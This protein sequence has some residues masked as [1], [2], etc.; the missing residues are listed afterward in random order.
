MLAVRAFAIAGLCMLI[1]T[2][3]FAGPDDFT[4]GETIPNYGKIAPVDVDQPVHNYS[5]FK[6]AFDTAKAANPGELNRTLTSAARFINMHAEAGVKLKNI[7]LAVVIHGGAT[8]DVAKNDYYHGHQDSE[9]IK[10]NANAELVK[11]LLNNGVEIYVCGQSATY[12]DLNNEDLLPGVQMSL[13]AMTAHA[14]LQQKGY[15]LNPF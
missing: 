12:Y 14:L 13:S 3:A 9:D 8:R 10:D 5:K 1:S 2:L 6:I 11:T 4:A 15:T 7:K